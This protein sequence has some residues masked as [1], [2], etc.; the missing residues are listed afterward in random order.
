MLL[1]AV[2]KRDAYSIPWFLFKNDLSKL[3]GVCFSEFQYPLVSLK[4][5]V[6]N[7]KFYENKN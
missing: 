7:G 2:K 3:Y 4:R 1:I 5:D 6:R